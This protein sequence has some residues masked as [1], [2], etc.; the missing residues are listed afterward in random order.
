M[1]VQWKQ[2]SAQGQVPGGAGQHSSS[3]LDPTRGF[4]LCCRSGWVLAKK[5]VATVSQVMMGGE[6]GPGLQAG[7]MALSKGSG[8][9]AGG[10]EQW[11]LLE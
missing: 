9:M 2:R 1:E 4:F 3:D 8:P 5:G 6:M 7:D 11:L 10:V